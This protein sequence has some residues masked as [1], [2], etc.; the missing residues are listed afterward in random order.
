[1]A[2][3]IFG[4][5]GYGLSRNKNTETFQ[6]KRGD[7]YEEMILSGEIKAE[8]FAELYFQNGGQLAWVGVAEGQ[9]VYQGQCG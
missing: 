9:K 8:K 2:A 7:V 3:A 4:L 5:R 6:V 1:M